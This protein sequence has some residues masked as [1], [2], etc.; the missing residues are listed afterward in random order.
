MSLQLQPQLVFGE[1][2]IDRLCADIMEF[3]LRMQLEHILAVFL[4]NILCNKCVGGKGLCKRLKKTLSIL[5]FTFIEYGGLNQI[6]S[7]L[8]LRLSLVCGSDGVSGIKAGICE[9]HIF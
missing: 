4:L 6:I 5:V 2:R 3:M 9:I 8:R 7:R 1:L